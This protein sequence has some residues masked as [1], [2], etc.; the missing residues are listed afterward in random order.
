MVRVILAAFLLAGC[1][2][3][4]LESISRQINNQ[5]EY[6]ADVGE[7]FQ[8][9]DETRDRGAGDCDDIAILKRDEFIRAGI[10]AHGV[11]L[12]IVQLKHSNR[13]HMLV[14]HGSIF[15]DSIIDTRG[16]YSD[17]FTVIY[18]FNEFNTAS[19]DGIVDHV[20]K[21]YINMLKRAGN[22]AKIHN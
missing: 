22:N 17:D 9:P 10:D 7:Y 20:N 11:T 2:S 14:K 5:V 4:R 19:G 1:Q 13:F 18:E 16:T 21:H 6:V 3:I 15:Y 8:T 12:V